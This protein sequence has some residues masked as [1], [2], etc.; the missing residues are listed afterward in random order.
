MNGNR[1]ML[2]IIQ[3]DAMESGMHGLQ[4]QSGRTEC[5]LEG[6]IAVPE[7]LEAEVWASGGWCDLTIQDGVLVAI[8]PT[9][10][11][12]EPEPEPTAQED[13]EAMLVDHEYRLT[14]LELGIV[15]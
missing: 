3:V 15:E 12:A 6:W 10:R 13:A 7:E 1:K 14:L 2:T 11:P 8:T 4:S 9:E 5:W